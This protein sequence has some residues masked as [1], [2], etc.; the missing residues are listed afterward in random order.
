[1]T[2]ICG[3]LLDNVYALGAGPYV[4]TEAWLPRAAVL[5]LGARQLPVAGR[6]DLVLLD[7]PEWRG[8][9][10]DI[11]DFKTGGDL[12]LS[13]RRMAHSGAS[14]Q[15]GVYLA[16]VRS[17][18]AAAGRV[19]MLRPE[20]G[21]ASGMDFADLDEGLAKLDWLTLALDRGTYGALTPDRSDYAP[22]GFDWPLACTPVRHAVLQAKYALTFR[23]E[24][25]GAD[26]E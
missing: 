16:G 7:R 9:R 14:L 24:E 11:I 26:D 2:R 10:V 3:V 15:L 19:W 5:T 6:L 8:A 12:D 4:A 18:G 1:M 20:P 21:A 22:G 13:A 17:L 25:K 23:A